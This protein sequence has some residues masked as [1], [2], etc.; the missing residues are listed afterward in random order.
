[1]AKRSSDSAI[2]QLMFFLENASDAAPKIATEFPAFTIS[3]TNHSGNVTYGT[4]KD[5]MRKDLGK[6]LDGDVEKLLDES[7]KSKTS[8][9]QLTQIKGVP[10]F[11][12]VQSIPNEPRCY[13][14]SYNF[15]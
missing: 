11:L 12:E 4:H 8:K 5:L 2:E 13:H 1:M 9:G 7:L 3:I 10:Y 14:C 15:V 6:I